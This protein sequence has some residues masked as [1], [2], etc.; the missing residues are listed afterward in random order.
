MDN[1]IINYVTVTWHMM[2]FRLQPSLIDSA[3][4]PGST[5]AHHVNGREAREASFDM[6]PPMPAHSHQPF[7]TWTPG[8]WW[9]S[10]EERI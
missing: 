5:L 7:Y 3:G 2:H 1:P 9:L 4:T 6:M 8:L 10:V